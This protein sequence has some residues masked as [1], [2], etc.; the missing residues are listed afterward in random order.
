MHLKHIIIIPILA[1]LVFGLTGCHDKQ[2]A[3]G[4][5]VM[6]ASISSNG[7]YVITTNKNRHAY[8]WDLKQHKQ[9]QISTFPVNIY[10]AYFIKHSSHFMIQNDDTNQVMI[11]SINGNTIKHFNPG[12]ASYG[13]VITHNLKDYFAA[14]ESLTV[15]Q[16]KLPSKQ[17]ITLHKSWCQQDHNHK[18]YSGSATHSCTH[19]FARG[20]LMNLTLTPDEQY[21]IGGDTGSILLWSIRTPNIRKNIS[22]VE[23]KNGIAV[24]PDG[25]Y[26]VTGDEAKGGIAYDL[27]NNKLLY[28]GEYAIDTPKQVTI[29]SYFKGVYNQN[30]INQVTGLNFITNNKYLVSFGANEDPFNYLGMYKVDDITW[31]HNKYGTF[32][33]ARPLKYLKLDTKTVTVHKNGKTHKKTIYPETQ[34]FLRSQSFDTAP[35]ANRVVMGQA[36]GGGIMVYQYDPDKQK[37]K[38]IWAP[39]LKEHEGHW[40]QFWK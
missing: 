4:N 23:T 36:N 16:I 3:K 1:F 22:G 7:R 30:S 12:F 18:Q 35:Q 13:E 6:V 11:K 29:K 8:L 40:W 33:S 2:R 15:E 19:F 20:K 9:K 21:L 32:P 14:K 37:L 34:S 24:S 28:G 5:E 17:T 27:K 31:R 10:S 25:H 26:V 38:L 39:Q